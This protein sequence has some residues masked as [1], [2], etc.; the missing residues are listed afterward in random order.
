MINEIGAKYVEAFSRGLEKAA[1]PKNLC[2]KTRPKENPYEVWRSFDG[3]WTWNVLKKNQLDDNKPY[4][5]WFC[6]VTSPYCPEGEYGDTYVKDI[7]SQAR[8]VA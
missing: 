8:K 5:I 7:K 6:F 1:K 2:K 4:A 3:T